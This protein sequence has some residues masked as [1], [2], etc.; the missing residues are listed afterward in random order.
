MEL[1]YKRAVHAG[2][3]P[4]NEFIGTMYQHG[5]G[6]AVNIKKAIHHFEIAAKYEQNVGHWNLGYI[7]AIQEGYFNDDRLLYHFRMA[8][9]LGHMD[10]RQIFGKYY[11]SGK[12][13]QKL[14]FTE[15]ELQ[16]FLRKTESHFSRNSNKTRNI[17]G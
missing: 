12:G 6:V 16:I 5:E 14:R 7:F 13:A 3:W 2:N 17:M 10:A 8:A 9:D 1:A 4:A 11:V 15:K